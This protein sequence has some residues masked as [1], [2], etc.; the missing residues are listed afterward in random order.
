VASGSLITTQR[1]DDNALLHARFVRKDV[2]LGFVNNHGA[3]CPVFLSSL[4]ISI[5][6]GRP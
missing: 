1:L 2:V 6:D 5:Q 3:F 4:Q